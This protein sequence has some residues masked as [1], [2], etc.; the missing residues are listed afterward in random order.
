MDDTATAACPFCAPPIERIFYT[1]GLVIGLWDSFPVSPGHALLVPRRH[2]AS[3]F[4]ATAEEKAALVAAID[5]AKVEIDRTHNPDAYN[6][7]VNIGAEAG[8]TIFHLHVHVIPRFKGDVTDPRG[9]VRY[10]LPKNANYLSQVEDAEKSNITIA[11]RLLFTGRSVEPFAATLK[12]HFA[13]AEQVDMAVAFVMKSGVTALQDAI[14]EALSRGTRVRLLTGDYLGATDPVALVQLLD[15]E[16]QQGSIELRVYQTEIDRSPSSGLATAFHPKAYIFV[17]RNGGGTAFIGSSNLSKSALS[18]GVEWNYRVV[19]SRDGQ[20][21]QEARTAFNRLFHSPWTTVLTEDWIEDYKGRRRRVLQQTTD[22][23]LFAPPSEPI[24]IPEPHDIQREAL[25]ALQRSR[26][27]GAEAGLVVLATGLGKTWLSAF[28]SRGF[29]RVL[30]V[31]HREEILDQAMRTYRRIRPND[32]LGRYDGEARHPNA[33]VL[34]ASIQTL[35]RRPHLERFAPNRFDYIVVDEFHH[36]SAATYRRL[37][38]HFQPGFLLGLTATP[39]RSDGANL[40]EL[41]GGNL[42]YRCD[43]AK[44]VSR[45]LLC[46]FDYF[47]VPDEVDYS[48]IPWRS[49]KFDEEKLTTAV[50]TMSRAENALEQLELRGGKRALAFCVS[51][52]HADFMSSFFVGRGKRAVAVHSGPNSAPRT[53]SLEK[54]QAGELDIVCAVD[55]FNEGVDLPDLDT[56]MMLRPTE[57]KILWLQQFGRGLRRSTGEKK[58]KVIDYI[59]NHRIFL[60]KPRTLFSL[61][62]G[63]VAIQNLLEQLSTHTAELPPGCSVTYDLKAIDIIRGLLRA[64]P[65]PSSALRAHVQDFQDLNGVRPTASEAFKDGFDPRTVRSHFGS[66]FGFLKSIGALDSSEL[67]ALDAQPEFLS[68][69]EVTPMN[70]SYKM[71]TLLAMLDENALPGAI[72]LSKLTSAVRR[73]GHAQ[74]RVAAD[75]GANYSS[76][77]ELRKCLTVN[78]IDAWV[79]G[80]GT[81]GQRYFEYADERF[82]TNMYVPTAARQTFQALVRELVDWRIAEYFD[83]PVAT[84]PDTFRSR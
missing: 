7:G 51:Q 28:D 77:S 37:L 26:D 72:G 6:I 15:F 56:V 73:I 11:D 60:L 64:S 8:Q 13:S 29:D 34:F 20:G 36:A 46:P 50:A 54:L 49:T 14:S 47:G 57:S 32:Y 63:D 25:E 1:D 31:A 83:S 66:W 2:V 3:W 41:C 17:D 5:K 43:L 27:G 23:A 42:V 18:D 84:R 52:R 65:P 24:Q 4:E 33:N 67:E 39:E 74:Q 70:R 58:L 82:G 35:S 16:S 78:P 69:L 22:D 53:I 81:S 30:F 10:V 61:P 48:N 19:S 44:G 71:V 79:R 9:G 40:L 59:G 55:M 68:T 21:F 75:F 45:N 38:Q 62:A 12:D 76:E 80:A